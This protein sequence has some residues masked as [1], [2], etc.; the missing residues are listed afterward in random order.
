MILILKCFF[1]T[2]CRLDR[3]FNTITTITE[4]TEDLEENNVPCVEQLNITDT[5]GKLLIPSRSTWHPDSLEYTEK[6]LLL[7]NHSSE[8]LGYIYPT[9]PDSDSSSK[10]STQSNGIITHLSNPKSSTPPGSPAQNKFVKLRNKSPNY[11][12]VSVLLASTSYSYYI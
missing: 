10:S 9:N 1:F 12:P 8:E 3:S 7:R 4:P 2:F 11:T 5:G 6:Q